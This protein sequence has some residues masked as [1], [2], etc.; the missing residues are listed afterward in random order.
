MYLFN[1]YFL[2]LGIK[3]EMSKVTLYLKNIL[4]MNDNSGI[5]FIYLLENDKVI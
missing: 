5:G 3:L 2:F 4:K 1:F